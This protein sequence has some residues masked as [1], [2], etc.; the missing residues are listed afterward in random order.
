MRDAVARTL[1]RRRMIAAAIR[2]VKESPV[3]ALMH[4][5]ILLLSKT[6]EGMGRRVMMPVVMDAVTRPLL[7][8]RL[9]MVAMTVAAASMQNQN[10]IS[11]SRPSTIATT[12]VAMSRLNH[13]LS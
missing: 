2:R 10:L 7:R 8:S 1:S 13:Q 12:A 3:L 5:V 9:R 11:G 6:M 4:V